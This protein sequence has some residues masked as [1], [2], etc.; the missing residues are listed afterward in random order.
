[1]FILVKYVIICYIER[2]NDLLFG[3]WGTERM[4]YGKT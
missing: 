4:T 2:K 3:P 1:M